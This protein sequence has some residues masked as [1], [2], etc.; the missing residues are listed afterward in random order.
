MSNPGRSGTRDK[1]DV[2]GLSLAAPILMKKIF[3]FGQKKILSPIP[4][5]V[6]K[7]Y[8]LNIKRKQN[9]NRSV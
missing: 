2:R 4:S 1:Y 5:A 7:F 6:A 8:F 9:E 3:L